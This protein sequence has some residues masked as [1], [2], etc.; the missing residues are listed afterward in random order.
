MIAEAKINVVITT[1]TN[2]GSSWEQLS[3]YSR[4]IFKEANIAYVAFEMHEEYLEE[5][6]KSIRFVGQEIY[7]PEFDLKPKK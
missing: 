6:A 2:P 4:E 7:D 5:I 3:Q 1:T